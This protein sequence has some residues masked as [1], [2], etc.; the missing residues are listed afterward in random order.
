MDPPGKKGKATV[1]RIPASEVYVDPEVYDRPNCRERLERVLPFVD[2]NEIREYDAEA[3]ARVAGIG[4][5]RHG[6]DEFGDD[7]VIAF[8]TF[9][10]NRNGW[11]YKWRDEAAA[12]GGACQPGLQLN[13]VNGCVFRCA[14]CG[15]GR[16]IEFS[17]DVERFID[18]LDEAFER[19]PGQR[20]FKYSNMTD[21]PPF[22]PE[23]DAVAPVIERFAREQDRYVMLFTKSDNV[24]FLKDLAHG[25]RTIISWSLTCET[26]SRLVDRRTAE[27]G[28]RIRAM[29]EMQA[30]GY[31]VRARL[32]PIVPVRNWKEEYTSLF[33]SLFEQVSPDVITLELLGWMGVEDLLAI[34][35]REVLDEEAV[36]AAEESAEQ[37]REFQWGP[38]T[39]KTHEDI[40]RHC[41]EEVHRLSP[42]T[43]ISV[44]HGTAA[45]WEALGDLMD[46]RPDRYVCNCG[47]LSAPGGKVYDEWWPELP[48]A[49]A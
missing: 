21:L 10:E 36:R 24:D 15:F 33:E 49:P 2:C 9:A 25:G 20:L 47:P 31:L 41:I 35:D 12:H 29:R 8:T 40:Y 13:T 34:F 18:G 19:C 39:Q 43:P 42:K 17:L 26:A 28:D 44:C 11:Y 46:M 16:R 48:K 3:K 14:Y 45:T 5:R 38:F 7:T 4:S 22:E 32:S 6:K 30:C 27:L 1:L 37:L 23:L